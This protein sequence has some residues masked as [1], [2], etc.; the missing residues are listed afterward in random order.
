MSAKILQ[1]VR[2]TPQPA[3]ELAV[4]VGWQPG[5]GVD[6]RLED[7]TQATAR[8]IVALTGE[9]LDAAVEQKSEVLVTF[10]GNDPSRPMI[11]GFVAGVPSEPDGRAAVPDTIKVRANEEIQ[12]RCGKASLT[13][14]RDGVVIV[15]GEQVI[16][17]AAKKNRITGGSVQIN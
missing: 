4:V 15:R 8:A 2:I 1:Q 9:Q 5:V 16:S 14:R 17:R 12:F 11:L 3:T 13:L 7:G 6:V 10:V